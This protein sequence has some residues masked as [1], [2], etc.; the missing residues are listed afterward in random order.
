MIVTLSFLRRSGWTWSSKLSFFSLMVFLYLWYF[1][2][3]LLGPVLS[4]LRI[5]SFM[6]SS[7]FS[8]PALT[9]SLWYFVGSTAVAF[10]GGCFSDFFSSSFFSTCFSGSGFFFPKSPPNIELKFYIWIWLK[11]FC[12]AVAWII[13]LRETPDCLA[14]W[15]INWN[16]FIYYVLLIITNY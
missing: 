13:N 11:A 5:L 8:F 10:A 3:R 6:S 9:L 4:T 15:A 16:I 14:C 1:P 7:S 12:W 2:N